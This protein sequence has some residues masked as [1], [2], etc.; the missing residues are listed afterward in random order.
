MWW[1]LYF[2]EAYIQK[3]LYSGFYWLLIGRRAS[4]EFI[5][6]YWFSDVE[7]PSSNLVKR[8]FACLEMG[9]S[10]SFNETQQNDGYK[11]LH[12]SKGRRCAKMIFQSVCL[13]MLNNSYYD[14]NLVKTKLMC[15][16]RRFTDKIRKKRKNGG[17][18]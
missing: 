1:G 8:K 11:R 12:L 9:L 15:L 7:K 17:Y 2:G 16:E 13:I 10:Y 5:S 14:R 6:K 3:S 18:M 4:C